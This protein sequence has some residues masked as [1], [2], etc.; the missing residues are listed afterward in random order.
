MARRMAASLFPLATNARTDELHFL[1][2]FILRLHASMSSRMLRFLARMSVFLYG[3]SCPAQ[4]F[5]TRSAAERT[6][7]GA[8]RTPS[9][10]SSFEPSS[11]SRRRRFACLSE[12]SNGCCYRYACLPRPRRFGSQTVVK[13]GPFCPRWPLPVAPPFV[14]FVPTAL[15]RPS[16]VH[17]NEK[18]KSN[19]PDPH[20][21]RCEKSKQ[22][23]PTDDRTDGCLLTIDVVVSN[24]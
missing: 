16:L 10:P 22:G 11:P 24:V 6:R 3:V 4:P 18:K 7:S 5:H 9:F 14:P 13:K 19:A 8:G 1:A 12:I 17:V 21:T 2:S 20:S 15:V 23:G